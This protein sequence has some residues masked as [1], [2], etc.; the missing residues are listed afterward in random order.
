MY[1]VTA[2]HTATSSNIH[3]E[4]VSHLSHIVMAACQSNSLVC[5]YSRLGP[6]TFIFGRNEEMRCWVLSGPQS[7]ST[8]CI[9]QSRRMVKEPHADNA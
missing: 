5:V 9:D 1:L 2:L 3:D 4:R 7:I 8:R 6:S